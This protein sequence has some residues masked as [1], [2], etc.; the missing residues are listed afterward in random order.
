MDRCRDIEKKYPLPPDS[1]HK[2]HQYYVAPKVMQ[3][4]KNA[5]TFGIG[6]DARHEGWLRYFNPDVIVQSFDPTHISKSTIHHENW[7]VMHRDRDLG[8]SPGEKAKL[9]WFNYAY[10]PS[11]KRVEFFT[12]DPGRKCYSTINIESKK[13]ID[14]VTV[15]TKN[16]KGLLET[17][18]HPDYIKFDVEGLWWEFVQ[19]LLDNNL[20]VSQLVG[21]FEMYFGDENLQF[22][23][24]NIIIQLMQEAGY[25]VFT[26]RILQTNMVELA[27][28][29]KGLV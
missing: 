22:E 9:Q 3:K 16:V 10:H 19:D 26:N 25:V 13:L 1:W 15:R 24:L 6:K 8:F 27:F 11:G 5:W 20:H 12:H 7:T 14:Q 4:M 17:Q 23:R 2:C 29:K 18:V 28:V 21:E